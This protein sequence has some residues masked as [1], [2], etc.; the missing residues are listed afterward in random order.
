MGVMGV[1]VIV[2]VIVVWVAR[3]AA[4]VGGSRYLLTRLVGLVKSV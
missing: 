4:V 3:A 1:L 2:M